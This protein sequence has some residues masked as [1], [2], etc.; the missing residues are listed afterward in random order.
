MSHEKQPFRARFAQSLPRVILHSAVFICAMFVGA[1]LL[2]I[3]L[4]YSSQGYYTDGKPSMGSIPDWIMAIAAL[5]SSLVGVITVAFVAR[6]FSITSQTLRETQEANRR[7]DERHIETQRSRLEETR[8][9]VLLSTAPS[10]GE[11]SS[12]NAV[13]CLTLKN[14]GAST[15]MRIE[16]DV[17]WWVAKDSTKRS[18]HVAMPFTALASQ[19]EGLYNISVPLTQMELP[20]D[21]V[22]V[23]ISYSDPRG[24]IQ[25]VLS[26]NFHLW[27]FEGAKDNLPYLHERCT[28]VS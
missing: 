13:I 18:L 28:K 20:G 12:G 14:F 4:G 7:Q 6:S 3:F 25:G 15:A 9:W 21:Y 23:C 17:S 19:S 22:S 16:G 24:V 10:L 8:P 11:T 27:N 5:F 2:L 1:V 26:Y